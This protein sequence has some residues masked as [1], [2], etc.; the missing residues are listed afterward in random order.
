VFLLAVVIW[1]YMSILGRQGGVRRHSAKST[2][3]LPEA[4]VDVRDAP[5][6]G[7]GAYALENIEVGSWVCRYV[8]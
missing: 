1:S 5:G 8:G 3:G 6:K 7:M 4:K 2:V